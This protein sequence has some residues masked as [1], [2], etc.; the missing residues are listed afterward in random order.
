MFRRRQPPPAPSAAESGLPPGHPHLSVLAITDENFHALTAGGFTVVAFWAAWCGPCRSFTPVFE[1]AAAA[2]TGDVLFGSCD[3]DANARVTE[4]L[5]I[6]SIPTLVVFGPDGSEI[7]RSL[8]T[9][10]RG[11]LE[12]TLR[13]VAGRAH[14]PTISSATQRAAPRG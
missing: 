4:L 9:V 12:A 13:R 3:I 14:E 8:G 5:Q 2:H 10:T 6:R 7:G 1:A 11:D